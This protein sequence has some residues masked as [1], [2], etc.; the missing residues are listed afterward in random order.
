M[1]LILKKLDFNGIFSHIKVYM[2]KYLQIVNV[3]KMMV[4]KRK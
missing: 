2:N 3:I 4:L 1:N